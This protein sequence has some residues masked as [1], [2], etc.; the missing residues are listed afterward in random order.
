MSFNPYKRLRNLFPEARLLVGAVTLAGDE[1]AT[2]ELPDGT[3]MRVRGVAA[4]GSQV[5]VRDGV[6]EGPAP[7]L[8]IV[9][10]EV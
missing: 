4:V 9:T 5:Y 10:I 3:Q 8:P 6:I 7:D 2:V 1:V